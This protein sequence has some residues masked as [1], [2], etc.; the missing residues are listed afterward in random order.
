MLKVSAKHFIELGERIADISTNLYMADTMAQDDPSGGLTDSEKEDIRQN[1]VRVWDVCNRLG[2]PIS[3]DLISARVDQSGGPPDVP[4]SQREFT[5]LID[6]VK[7]EIRNKLFMFV[8]AHLAKYYESDALLS[9]RARSAF[10]TSTI[11]IR[12][13]GSCLAAGLN[14]ASVFH[15]MRAVEHGLRA[16]AN[17]VGVTFEAQQWKNV[18]D[19]IESEIRKLGNTLPAGTAKTERLQFLSQASAGFSHFKDGW[20]NHVM[21]TRASYDEAQATV[22]IENVRVFLDALSKNLRELV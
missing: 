21:H 19:Q 3:G 2:L 9:E 11:E 14:T 5:L 6:A 12:N 8:P 15:C 1:L 10:P 16:L 20:R 13:A 17:N 4:Q 18:I 22:V 7:A